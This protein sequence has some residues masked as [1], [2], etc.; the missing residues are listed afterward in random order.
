MKYLK[1][2]LAIFAFVMAGFAALAFNS[3]L[4]ESAN[5]KRAL[6]P[7]TQQWVDIPGQ[8]QG[9]DYLCVSAEAICTAEFSASGQMVPNSEIEGEFEAL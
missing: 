3:P 6:N 7:D 9:S 1:N 5:I 8:Q 4:E 2:S